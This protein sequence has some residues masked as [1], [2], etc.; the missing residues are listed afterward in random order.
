MGSGESVVTEGEGGGGGAM[1]AGSLCSI[2]F[3]GVIAG[4][5]SMAK[6]Q[7]R[8]EF[9][10]DCIGSAFN[11][12]GMMQCPNCRNVEKG[13][14]RY[15]NDNSLSPSV[16][17]DGWTHADELYELN[18]LEIPYTIRWCPVNRIGRVTSS[19]GNADSSPSGPFE[20][21]VG[22]NVFTEL[23]SISV[24][25][26]PCPHFSGFDQAQTAS[27]PTFHASSGIITDTSLY[28]PQWSQVLDFAEVPSS[29]SLHTSDAHY[30]GWD[31]SQSTYSHPR[32]FVTASNRTSSGIVT[33][34]SLYYPQWSQ[35]SDS[36]EVP[37]SLSLHTSDARYQGW[38]CSQSTYSHPTDI[39]TASNRAPISHAAP[40]HGTML[41]DSGPPGRA[42]YLSY[43]FN[44]R[45]YGLPVH[46]HP[47]RS[48]RT[49]VH[50][51]ELH[52]ETN[53]TLEQWLAQNSNAG[54]SIW[55]PSD[56]TATDV[57]MYPFPPSFNISI[58]DMTNTGA[59][60]LRSGA[61]LVPIMVR[62]S[63]IESGSR[64]FFEH[65]NP[66]T[67][68]LIVQTRLDNSH[69]GANRVRSPY[70]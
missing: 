41:E 27:A 69:H 39:V 14:W 60:V 2:C 58:R 53:I 52:Q 67:E 68:S 65:R 35:V 15:G 17:M 24:P 32:D 19:F 42:G 18:F 8:H 25:S 59:Q 61:Q 33:D 29:L 63:S 26:H 12:K 62:S 11:A 28:H 36:A 37:S 23:P 22:P 3:E 9:H 46:P 64:T 10:L 7:C 55:P 57:Y 5:R 48:N 20:D 30:Q 4:G 50:N 66:S 43:S 54:R 16:S 40:P 6:L 49:P 34:T 31:R 1:D 47:N 70:F 38:D 45:I 56:H 13:N 51:R 44:G 21:F